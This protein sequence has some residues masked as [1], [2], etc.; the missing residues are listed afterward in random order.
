MGITYNV[1]TVGCAGTR[2]PGRRAGL[3]WG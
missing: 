3:A 2:T 1:T